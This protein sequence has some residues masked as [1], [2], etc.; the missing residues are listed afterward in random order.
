MAAVEE[1]LDMFVSYVDSVPIEMKRVSGL[2]VEVA[3][4]LCLKK[5]PIR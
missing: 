1:I 3:S 5:S 4:E 2:L